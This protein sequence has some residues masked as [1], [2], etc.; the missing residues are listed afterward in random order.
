MPSALFVPGLIALGVVVGGYGTLIGAG[1]GF[2]LVPVLLLLYPHAS[3]EQVTAISLAA[4]LANSASGSV[5]YYRLGRIDYRTGVILAAATI[6]GAVLGTILVDRFPRHAFDVTMGVALLAIAVF[7]LLRPSGRLTLA[8][9]GPFVITRHLVDAQGVDYAYRFN[10]G[11][12]AALSVGIGLLSSLLGIGGGIVHVP[13]L[14]TFFAFPAHVATATSQFVL[15]WMA[16]AAT[17]T[18]IL[19]GDYAGFVLV[20]VSLAVGV[21]AGAQGGAILSRRVGGVVILRLL[22][23][24]L[25]LVG[26][27]LV[28]LG[29]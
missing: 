10:L 14:T 29:I 23:V 27:R 22:A 1:G 11:L 8:L 25:G 17:G 12:A 13:L 3:P 2:I 7:I 24:G 18:H 21:I 5:G 28:L 15:M 20:T 16:A 19:R 6:P 4:V 9:D 26:L